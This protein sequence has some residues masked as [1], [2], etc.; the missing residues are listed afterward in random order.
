MEKASV[1]SDAADINFIYK[2]DGK[3]TICQDA[4][5][6][7][8]RINLDPEAH[9]PVRQSGQQHPRRL[10]VYRPLFAEHELRVTMNLPD[11]VRLRD[12]GP[13]LDDPCHP[14]RVRP[15]ARADARAPA[16]AVRPLVRL[17][18]NLQDVRLDRGIRQERRSASSPIRSSS[19]WRPSATTTSNRSCSTTSPRMSSSRS[20]AR[21][22]PATARRRSTICRNRTSPASRC[23]TARRAAP[24]PGHAQGAA[25][26][27]PA[28]TPDSAV[29]AARADLGKLEHDDAGGGL[30]H[31]SGKD[32]G[33]RR[34]PPP[35]PLPMSSLR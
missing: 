26:M 11:V 21:R 17:P 35:P 22:T 28:S 12:E 9:R 7:F 25:D 3:N 14:P 24:A 32:R 6:A 1:W 30:R 10:V 15:R 20:P 23:S 34:R 16:G 27:V 31:R 29:A 5:S 33:R 4:T 13:A 8:F 2:T 18:G 19:T